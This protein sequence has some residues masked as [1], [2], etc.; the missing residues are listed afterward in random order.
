MK[1]EHRKAAFAA[2]VFGCGMFVLGGLSDIAEKSGAVP[3]MLNEGDRE[4][5]IIVLDAGHDGST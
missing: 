2:V 4:R 3:V 1:N 5:P